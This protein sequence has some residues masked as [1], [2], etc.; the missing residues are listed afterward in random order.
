ML[1]LNK[2]NESTFCLAKLLLLGAP[3]I[4]ETSMSL[5]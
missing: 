1:E 2:R 5:V 3:L 4:V